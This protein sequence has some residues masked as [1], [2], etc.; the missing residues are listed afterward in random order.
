MII[1]GTFQEV[2]IVGVA[3]TPIGSFAGALATISAP[4]LGSIA[5][6]GALERAHVKASDVGEVIMGNVIS[7][8]AGQAPARQAAK[9][10]GCS[11]SVCCTTVNKVCASGMKAITLGAQSIMLG[12]HSV[13]VAGGMESMSNI[14][15][16]SRT[17]RKG[18]G[19]VGMHCVRRRCLGDA[20]YPWYM[21]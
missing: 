14:P 6:S 7:A 11:D 21:P 19:T 4:K 16:I 13:V 10:A 17:A 12:N 3:R 15:Y 5:I 9:G 20:S 8:G 18:S 2:V 1:C